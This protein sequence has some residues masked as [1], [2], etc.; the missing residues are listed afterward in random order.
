MSLARAGILALRLEIRLPAIRNQT[1]TDAEVRE[2]L[3]LAGRIMDTDT[4]INAQRSVMER[5][6]W[7]AGPFFVWRMWDSFIFV[8]MTLWKRCDLL[9]TTER[10]QFWGRVEK[11]YLYHAGL[12]SVSQ[13]QPMLYVGFRRLTLKAWDAQPSKYS[14]GHVLAFI[15]RLSAVYGEDIGQVEAPRIPAEQEFLP[16]TGQSDLLDVFDL[17]DID[18]A[19]T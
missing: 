13:S 17:N 14:R 5:F 7:H 15:D 9:S 11:V 6:H 8:L 3:H 18:W 19:A 4:A 2:A 1:A 12:L 16:I 10:D